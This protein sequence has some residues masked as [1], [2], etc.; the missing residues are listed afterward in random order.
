MYR[1]QYTIQY[2]MHIP[3]LPQWLKGKVST[4]HAGDVGSIPVWGKI[5]LE[6]GMAT[7]SSILAGRIPWT[8]EPGGLWSLD[9]KDSRMTVPTEHTG[10]HVSSAF[11]RTTEPR[12]QG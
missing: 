9:H 10:M 6:E 4:C 12:I 5:P 11:P 1:K 3:G 8:E 2:D 7:H